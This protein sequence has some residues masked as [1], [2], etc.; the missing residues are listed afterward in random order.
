MLTT[1][2]HPR[3]IVH[4]LIATETRSPDIPEQYDA[5]GWLVGSWDLDVRF[6]WAKDVSNQR[7]KAEAHFAWALEG[8]AIQD[9]WIMPRVS[10]RTP[11]LDPMMN[12]YGTT[13]RVWDATLKAWR[14]TWLNPAGQHFEQQI[15][16]RVGTEVVQLGVRPDGTTTRWRFT[17]ITG[18]SFHWIGES[19]QPD[20]RTWALE[21]EFLARRQTG[22]M[23]RN[24]DA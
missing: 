13:L 15:G 11:A 6:Y 9:V 24:R 2:S 4:A 20:G 12:M 17:E 22:A 8:R 21:G 16:R 23:K 10:D 5:Y 14:I 1:E 7:I 3:G 18:D 19:L